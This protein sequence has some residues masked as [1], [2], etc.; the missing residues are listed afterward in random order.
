M[1]HLPRSKRAVTTHV[2]P[3]LSTSPDEGPKVL[4]VGRFQR[5][6]C[7]NCGGFKAAKVVIGGRIATIH[8]SECVPAPTAGLDDVMDDVE[9]QDNEQGPEADDLFAGWA[10]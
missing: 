3:D 8:C 9:R 4:A 6:T 5:P 7:D 2:N 10:A 1:R